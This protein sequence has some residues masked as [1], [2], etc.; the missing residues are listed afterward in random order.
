MGIAYPAVRH[1]C[2]DSLATLDPSFVHKA[3]FGRNR[4]HEYFPLFSFPAI[5]SDQERGAFSDR[6]HQQ[7][8]PAFSFL[9]FLA[10]DCNDDVTCLDTLSG[11]VQ[12][13]SRQ[14]FGNLQTG[15][16]VLMVEQ[17]SYPS[18]PD[19]RGEIGSGSSVRTVEFA[20]HLREKVLEIELVLDVWKE[21]PVV[22]LETLPVHTVDLRVVE[23]FIH[24]FPDMVE[25]VGTFC[26][27]LELIFT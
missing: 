15:P 20:E 26:A 27:G 1:L 13:A 16:L 21:L 3:S 22:V 23:L 9:D 14:D 24:L 5:P 19:G 6:V 11:K 25:D 12:R 4:L 10:V 18:H 2:G 7:R 17:G 8:E